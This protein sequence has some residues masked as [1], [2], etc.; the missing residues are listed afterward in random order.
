MRAFRGAVCVLII[1]TATIFF[2]SVYIQRLTDTLA[3]KVEGVTTDNIESAEQ[4]LESLYEDFKSAEKYISL[5]V[6][7]DDLTNIEGDFAEILGAAKAGDT[8]SV[9][10]LKSRLVSSLKHLGRLSG[11]SLESVI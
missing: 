6:S 2:N 7:H 3:Q 5:T 9:I 1:L 10:T 11:I 4:V 8:E